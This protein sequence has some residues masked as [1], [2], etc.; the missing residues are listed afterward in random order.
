MWI[1]RRRC[2]NARTFFSTAGRTSLE[3][4][5]DATWLIA[6]GCGILDDQPEIHRRLA[7]ASGISDT[8]VRGA[9]P[10]VGEI[11]VRALPPGAMHRRDRLGRNRK[12]VA[13]SVDELHLVSERRGEVGG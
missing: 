1:T 2:Q 8:L 3:S 6:L 4:N 5:R 9:E 10:D 11:C 7:Y 13:R 12:R